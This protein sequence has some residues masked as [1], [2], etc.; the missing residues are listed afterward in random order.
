MKTYVAVAAVLFALLATSCATSYQSSDES[1]TGGFSEIRLA[2]TM[3]RVRVEGNSFTSRTEAEG[4]LLRRAAELTLEQGKRYFVLDQHRAWIN[5]VRTSQTSV[6]TAPVNESVV[7]AL[8]TAERDA[9]DA[10][11]IVAET[12][13][14]AGRK[15]SAAAKK[16]LES[17]QTGGS[18]SL[19]GVA[20]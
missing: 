5:A 3:W 4:F 2:P 9:F 11:K 6:I 10:L 20:R 19:G 12:D 1:L 18:D 8:D 7:T 13:R 14:V 15:L 16:T 17:L